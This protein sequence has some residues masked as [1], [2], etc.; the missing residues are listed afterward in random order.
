M[1]GLSGAASIIAV[2]DISD[3]IVSLCYQYS[4]AVKDVKDY[5]E[6]VQRKVSDITYI[7]EKIKQPLDN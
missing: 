7:L 4:I 1:D 5:I 3:K 6:R 2:V